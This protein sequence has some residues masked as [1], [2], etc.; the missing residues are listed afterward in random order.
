MEPG[1]AGAPGTDVAADAHRHKHTGPRGGGTRRGVPL[2]P[3][4]DGSGAEPERAIRHHRARFQSVSRKKA[5]E[6]GGMEMLHRKC[7]QGVQT[8]NSTSVSFS[9]PNQVNLLI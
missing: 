4:A 5:G 6:R 8:A 7:T 3:V 2:A 1:S 9:L